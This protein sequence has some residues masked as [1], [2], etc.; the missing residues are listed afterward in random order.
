M[1]GDVP[2]KRSGDFQGKLPGPA[3]G[4]L[5]AQQGSR[6]AFG[7]ATTMVV[8]SPILVGSSKARPVKQKGSRTGS[9]KEEVS[10]QVT[11]FAGGQGNE[12]DAGCRRGKVGS[13]GQRGLHRDA[14]QK[15]V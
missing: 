4:R 3:V 6:A 12:R 11:D 2:G 8:A 15:G 14:D 1:S 5:A 13:V 9:R 10:Q 7:A